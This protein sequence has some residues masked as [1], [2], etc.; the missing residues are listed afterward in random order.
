MEDLDLEKQKFPTGKF[1]FPAKITKEGIKNFISEIERL[2]IDLRN[3]VSDLS[4]EQ[5]NTKY[6]EGGWT[7]RQVVHHIAD[8]HMNSYIRF[9][10]SMTED[11]VT[12]KPYFEDRWAELE[13]G[14]N[15]DINISLNL[16]EALHY[17]WVM[18]LDS[19]SEEDF[20][21]TYFHPE[22][23]K[24]FSL[25]TSLAMYSWHGKHHNAHIA[26]LKKR[27]NR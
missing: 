14:K 18:F 2:P 9:K 25:A 23:Q 3:L 19:M 16:I 1:K 11:S 13:D 5:F 6:R 24:E 7:V 22:L 4:E 12:I 20:K 15:C 17:R 21:K 10:L 8:S 27:N 26:E